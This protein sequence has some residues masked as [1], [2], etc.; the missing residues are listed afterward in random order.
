MSLVVTCLLTIAD[1]IMSFFGGVKIYGGV[2][3][4]KKV[5]KIIVTTGARFCDVVGKLSCF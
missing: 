3:Q 4:R 5:L 1:L 2:G